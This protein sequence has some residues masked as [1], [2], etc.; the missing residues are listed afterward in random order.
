MESRRAY[1]KQLAARSAHAWG[2]APLD[3]A[4]AG[5]TRVQ[6]RNTLYRMRDGV[7]YA[8]ERDDDPGRE[9]IHASALVGM[10]IVGWVSRD[11]PSAGITT[12]WRAGSYAVLWRP[13][14]GGEEHSAIALTSSTLAFRQVARIAPRPPPSR[15]AAPVKPTPLRAPPPR[16]PRPANQLE[17]SADA[18]YG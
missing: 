14:E 12:S 5:E 6:T 7:C 11:D 18:S 4:F 8:V 17:P 16:L 1:I 9:R 15:P 13:R 2:T 3:P 10:R